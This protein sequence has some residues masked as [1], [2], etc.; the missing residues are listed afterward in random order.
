MNLKK[1]KQ[2]IKNRLLS[3]SIGACNDKNPIK[4][5]I[6]TYN[7][8]ISKKLLYNM[9]P[10]HSPAGP[11]SESEELKRIIA[12]LNENFDILRQEYKIKEISIV[13]SYARGEQ[14]EESD[15]DVMVDFDE[16]IGLEVVDLRDK[17]EEILKIKVDL[18]LKSGIMQRKKLYHSMLEDV[19]HVK[20]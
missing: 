19:V 7:I 1:M 2:S 11:L 18:I 10:D 20:A 14:T 9:N 15:L 6:Y 5:N 17:L 16:P 12:K 3:K 4:L 13:G 8:K